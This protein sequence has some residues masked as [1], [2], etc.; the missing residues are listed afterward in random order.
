MSTCRRR[1][2]LDRTSPIVIK[3]RHTDPLPEDHHEDCRGC[4]PCTQRHCTVCSTHLFGVE[5]QTC[6]DCLA[7]TRRTVQAIADLAVLLPGHAAHAARDGRLA[8]AAPIP[9]SD[10]LVLLVGGSPGYSETG[11]GDDGLEPMSWV[12]GWWEDA[13]R[14]WLGLGRAYP[15]NAEP[16]RTVSAAHAFLL[17]HLSTAADTYPGFATMHRDLTRLRTTLE[18]VLHAGEAPDHGVGCFDCGSTLERDYRRPRRCGCGPRPYPAHVAHHRTDVCC[19]GCATILRWELQHASCDQGGLTSTD[20]HAGWH[21][22]RCARAY[23]PAEY[24]LALRARYDEVAEY[25]LLAD[26]I[27]LTGAKRGSIE[28]WASKGLVRRRRDGSGRV[29]YNVPDVRARLRRAASSE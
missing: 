1:D 16:R 25:R 7:E 3:G 13:L 26:T 19:N 5:L 24:Q 8:A 9:G 10:A 18:S 12:L 6:I 2:P 20:L 27:R 15:T 22:P 21:C 11:D 28:G 23:T 14:Q 17:Q 29:T 4:E